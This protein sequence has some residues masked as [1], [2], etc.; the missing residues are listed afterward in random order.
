V[1]NSKS[2]LKEVVIEFWDHF[3]GLILRWEFGGSR[4]PRLTGCPTI[5]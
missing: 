3:E 1:I 5:Q 4:I 2:R